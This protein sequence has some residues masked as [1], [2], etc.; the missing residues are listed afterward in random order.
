M[1][2]TIEVSEQLLTRAKRRAANEGLTLRSVFEQALQRYL[3]E[4]DGQPAGRRL[5]DARFDGGTD[6]TPLVDLSDWD[7]VRETIDR[8]RWSGA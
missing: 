8:E 4:L 1:K 6:S 7:A 5:R 3:D 2:T